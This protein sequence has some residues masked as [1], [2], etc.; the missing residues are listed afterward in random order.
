MKPNPLVCLLPVAAAILLP[1]LA[2]AAPPA[3]AR[4]H[5]FTAAKPPRRPAPARRIKPRGRAF[6]LN[7]AVPGRDPNRMDHMALG[8][9]M[10]PERMDH[11]NAAPRIRRGPVTPK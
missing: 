7:G 10:H 2:G 5:E 4:P 6:I 11:M 3:H 9:K 1:P 8:Q